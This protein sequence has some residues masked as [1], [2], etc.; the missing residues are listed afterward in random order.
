MDLKQIIKA[1]RSYRKFIHNEKIDEGIIME[2]IDNARYVASSKNRQPV[3][4]IIITE[5]MEV[6]QICDHMQWARH[7]KNWQGPTKEQ[8]P[9]ALLVV[10]T[11]ENINKNAQTDVGIITQTILLQAVNDGYGGCLLRS[12]DRKLIRNKF[13]LPE[14]IAIDMVVA[15]G[16]PDQS[17]TLEEMDV[18]SDNTDYWEDENGVHHVPKRALVDFVLNKKFKG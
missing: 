16:K 9:A 11:D 6:Q 10:C 14:N 15:L 7:L 13:N 8:K 17:I 5:S 18:N 2:W 1:N 12:I 3:R 4:F